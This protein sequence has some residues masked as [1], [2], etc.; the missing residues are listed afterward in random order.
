MEESRE[1][2][3]K[4]YAKMIAKAWSDASFKERLLADPRA[5]LEAEGISV[6]P[7][8]DVKVLEQTDMQLFLV[9]PTP[10]LDVNIQEVDQRMATSSPSVIG[11]MN[12][13]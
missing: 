13:H 2:Q 11:C 8:V 6:P 1:E 9:I 7:G 5:V 4:K 12:C 10:P 3:D